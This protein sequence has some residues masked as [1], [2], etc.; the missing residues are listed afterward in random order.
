[1]KAKDLMAPIEEYLSPEMSLCEAVTRMRGLK[2]V[3]GLP[4]K[5]MLVKDEQ[6][7]VV[8][9]VSIKDILRAVIPTYLSPDLSIFSWDN[10]LEQMSN[11]ASDK[12]VGDIMVKELVTIDGDVPLMVCTDLM[13]KKG[14]QRLPVTDEHDE[15]IGMVYI[16]DIFNIVSEYIE[17]GGKEHGTC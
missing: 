6:G 8:G 4:I 12:A 16:R 7:K 3:H 15:I 13:I 9:M 2:R 11:R 1:M 10:M 14:L 5:G 17:K